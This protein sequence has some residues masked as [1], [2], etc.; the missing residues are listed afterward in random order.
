MNSSIAVPYLG[1]VT[2]A[3][4]GIWIIIGGLITAWFKFKPLMARLRN[5]ADGSLRGD[6]LKRISA[7]ELQQVEDRKA[8]A[9]ER[10]KD[11]RDCQQE[12]EKL[13]QRIRE[14]DK[15]IDGLQRSLIMF[16]LASGRA[17]PPEMRSPEI[18]RMMEALGPIFA[19]RPEEK[20]R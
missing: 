15:L 2:P 17:L 3:G 8:H 4:A 6:L 1:A 13:N 19:A 5:E 16:Q 11:R 14:Q 18:D 12:T 7:L 9:L 20:P 10:E